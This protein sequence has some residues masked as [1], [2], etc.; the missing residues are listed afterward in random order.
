MNQPLEMT[1]Q[2]LEWARFVAFP[3]L[4]ILILLAVQI[5]SNRGLRQALGEV[6]YP[7]D[8]TLRA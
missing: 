8:E 6:D 7:I 1:R 3:I 2:I 5:K 4:S